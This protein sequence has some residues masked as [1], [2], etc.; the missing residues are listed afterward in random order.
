MCEAHLVK[1]LVRGWV[2]IWIGIG[3]RVVGVGVRP[4]VRG[5]WTRVRVRVRIIMQHL[6]CILRLRFDAVPIRR[7]EGRAS[8]VRH[9]GVGRRPWL[10]LGV[11][12]RFRVRVRA[13]IN[14]R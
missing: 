12:V 11:R 9:T 6:V 2:G 10:G 3:V 14:H 8:H 7:R 13:R 1:D 5:I 4:R